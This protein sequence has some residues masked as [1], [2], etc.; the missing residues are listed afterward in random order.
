MNYIIDDFVIRPFLLLEQLTSSVKRQFL[1]KYL[2]M[3]LEN[4]VVVINVITCYIH[5][6]SLQCLFC[7]LERMIRGPVIDCQNPDLI[8]LD[9]YLLVCLK[10]IVKSRSTGNINQVRQRVTDGRDTVTC[11]VFVKG[12]KATMNICSH[13]G[14]LP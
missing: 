3:L 13:F 2:N 9:F 7:R 14:C 1:E 8:P 4:V 6:I 10:Q 11:R 12:R 5:A